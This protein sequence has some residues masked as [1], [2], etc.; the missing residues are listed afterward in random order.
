MK[1]NREEFKELVRLYD[2]AWNNYCKYAEYINE[3]FLEELM[4]PALDW[5]KEKVGI[6]KPGEDFDVI[7]DLLTFGKAAIN[8]TEDECEWTDDL[9]KIYDYYIKEEN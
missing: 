4:F 6:Y 8:F 1:I 9:D 3:S 5:M 7:M 2:E